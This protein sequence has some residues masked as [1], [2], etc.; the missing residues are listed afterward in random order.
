MTPPRV[1]HRVLVEH[2]GDEHS[3]GFETR[4]YRV[5]DTEAIGKWGHTPDKP[6]SLIEDVH[7]IQRD[8]MGQL[9]VL[10]VDGEQILLSN[11]RVVEMVPRPPGRGEEGA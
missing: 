10:L 4:E 1:A 9:R 7:S 3:T 8:D 6:I 2:L 5:H 11:V